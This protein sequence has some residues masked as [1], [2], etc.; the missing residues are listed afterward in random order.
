MQTVGL[1][2]P[3]ALQEVMSQSVVAPLLKGFRG[4]PAIDVTILSGLMQKIQTMMQENAHIVE[5]DINPLIMSQAGLIQGVD[6][7]IV[8]RD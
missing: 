6:A 5:I 2:P 3:A 7:R 4:F 1:L 8:V